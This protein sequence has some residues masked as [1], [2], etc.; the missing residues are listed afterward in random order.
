ML[1]PDVYIASGQGGS[2]GVKPGGSAGKTGGGLI[3][4]AGAT[5]SPTTPSSGVNTSLAKTPCE[6]YCAGYG[7][8]CR[9]LLKGKDCLTTCQDELNGSGPLCQLLGIETLGCLT[10]FFS[11]KGGDC[12]GAVNRALTQCEDLV[13]AFDECK[14]Q[15][16]SGKRNPV[17]NCARSGDGGANPSCI[18]IFTCATGASPYV[19]FCSPTESTQLVECACAPPTG[20][21][22]MVRI[23][24]SQDPCLDATTLCP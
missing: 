19:T 4:T 5:T 8:Q 12:G 2:S 22:V 17:S 3:G 11:P 14:S 6:R 10:P 16:A 13:G 20:E 21:V 15:F 18:G 23:P 9:Q 24:M 1:D 7:T